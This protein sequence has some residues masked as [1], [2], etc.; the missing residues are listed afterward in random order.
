MNGIRRTARRLRQDQRGQAALEFAI[1]AMAMILVSIG[2]VEF[3]RALQVRNELSF[4]ADFGARQ[5]LTNPDIPDTTVESKIRSVFKGYD[6]SQLSVVLGTETADG[7]NF[8]TVALSYPFTL[9]IPGLSDPA[10]TLTVSRRTP[11]F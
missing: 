6:A 5:I 3:G 8:R 9:L 1:I 11:K 2:I 4:A 7:L 10:V